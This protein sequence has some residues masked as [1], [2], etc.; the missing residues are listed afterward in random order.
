MTDNPSHHQFPGGPQ[1]VE[2]RESLYVGYHFYDSVGRGVLFPFGH[3]LSYTTFDNQEMKLSKN[4]LSVSDDLNVSFKIKN[5]GKR[6]G[7][8][9]VQV[10]VR[11]TESTLFRPDKEL[12]G[13]EKVFLEPGEE[14]T[15][16]IA[17]NQRAFA[18]YDVGKGDWIVESGEYEILVGSSSRDIRL[19]AIVHIT[20]DEMRGNAVDNRYKQF[21][22]NGEVPQAAFETLLGRPVPQ[23]SYDAR[24]YSLNTSI[25]DMHGSIIGRILQKVIRKQIAQM[26]PTDMYQPTRLMIEQMALESPMRVLIMFSNG[27]LNRGAL[28]GLLHLANGKIWKGIRKL[29]SFR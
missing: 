9:I 12:K 28:E 27:T 8:E 1:T 21:P 16:I 5:T 17:L 3:G 26:I 14:K 29:K 15:I 25:M 2:Y 7:K 10:Y 23:N 6:V 18:F 20:G 19:T 4:H 24:P 13:F 22:A 11:D